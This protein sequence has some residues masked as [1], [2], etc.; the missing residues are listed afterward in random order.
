MNDVEYILNDK[1][2]NDKKLVKKIIKKLTIS[3]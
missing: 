2:N 1:S 3:S